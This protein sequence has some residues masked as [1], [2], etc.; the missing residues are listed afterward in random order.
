MQERDLSRESGPLGTPACSSWELAP[1]R[2][3]WL[4]PQ[5]AW[6]GV[7]AQR[8][9][10]HGLSVA[11]LGYVGAVSLLWPAR[12][13]AGR[14]PLSLGRLNKPSF[15]DSFLCEARWCPHSPL[16]FQ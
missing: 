11:C 7:L 8:P 9:V 2:V 12:G 1:P 5:E 13:G 15:W 3:L 14:N 10:L 6:E 4:C 16:E